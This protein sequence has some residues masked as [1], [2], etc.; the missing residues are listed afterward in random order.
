MPATW[1]TL[2]GITTVLNANDIHLI[3]S[4]LTVG[5]TYRLFTASGNP[6]VDIDTGST[7]QV[8]SSPGG[9]VKF[10]LNRNNVATNYYL[11]IDSAGTASTNRA[12][13][14][15][16]LATWTTS[17]AGGTV[18]QYYG[19]APVLELA[20]PGSGQV[21]LNWLAATGCDSRLSSITYTTRRAVSPTVPNTNITTGITA[22][23]NLDTGRTNG[24][25]Y[26]YLIRATMKYADDIITISNIDSNILNVTPRAIKTYMGEMVFGV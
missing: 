6:L 10:T 22:L 13:A 24:T 4:G 12:V 11:H 1:D 25:T 15:S 3:G 18:P 8:A 7:P 23:S 2:C 21:I 14:T 16:V 20:M 5:N 9:H 26:R 17:G 19:S